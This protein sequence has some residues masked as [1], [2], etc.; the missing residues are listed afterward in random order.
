MPLY[1][2][3]VV[4]LDAP[5]KRISVGNPAIADILILRS[6]QLYVL[7]KDLGTTN[8]LL[9]DSSDRLIGTVSVEVTHD[10]QALKAKLHNLMPNEEISIYSA[11]R[12][13]VLAGRVSN[14]GNMNAA[15]RIAEGYFKQGKSRAG[16]GG[17]AGGNATQFAAQNISDD[18]VGE[19][20]NMLSV[21][22]AQQVM[23]EVKVAEIARTELKRLDVQ[24]NTILT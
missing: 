5:A 11:Q 24:F 17:G 3:R 18:S 6:T 1:K 23:L 8:V 13:I 7:G 2:S 10:L 22:G 19:V 15:V 14:V 9:W 21:G 12:N 4:A 20:I 16:R